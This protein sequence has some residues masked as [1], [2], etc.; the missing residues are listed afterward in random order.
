MSL[1][2]SSGFYQINENMFFQVFIRELKKVVDDGKIG[3]VTKI[4]AMLG[5][6]GPSWGWNNHFLNPSLSGEGGLCRIW[7]FM[8]LAWLMV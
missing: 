5:H 1:R 8:L 6:G 4:S 7:E 3:T 2:K